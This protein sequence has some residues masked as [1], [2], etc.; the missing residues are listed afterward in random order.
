MT[1]EHD[2]RPEIIE[3]TKKEFDKLL[4][5]S[6]TLPTVPKPGFRWKCNRGLFD[7]VDVAEVKMAGTFANWWMAE[8]YELDPPELDVVGIRWKKIKLKE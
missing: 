5:Y 1:T 7:P 8:I 2:I 6:T 3:L 4:E